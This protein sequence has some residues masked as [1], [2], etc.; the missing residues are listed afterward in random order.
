MS[1]EA[2]I[3]A[4]RSARL[5]CEL[6]RNILQGHDFG[7]LLAAISLADSLGPVLDPTLYREKHG[8]MAEDRKAF[9]AAAAFLRTW[10]SP[11][12]RRPAQI[13]KPS[14]PSDVTGG[15]GS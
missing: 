4:Y 5:D 13:S 7:E 3:E 8:A 14:D 1:D 2:K 15:G 9:E 6:A 12:N 10:P 11:E